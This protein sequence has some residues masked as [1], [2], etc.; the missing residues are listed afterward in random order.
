MSQHLTGFEPST[1]LYVLDLQTYFTI[2]KLTDDWKTFSLVLR[3][4]RTVFSRV[5]MSDIKKQ[6]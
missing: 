3:I 4:F 5:S 2:L 1:Y 6:I